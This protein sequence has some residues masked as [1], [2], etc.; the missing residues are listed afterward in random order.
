MRP[1]RI[2][3]MQKAMEEGKT[4]GGW[5]NPRSWDANTALEIQRLP[6]GGHLSTSRTSLCC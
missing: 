6:A 5:G 2:I 4:P 1:K 3:E